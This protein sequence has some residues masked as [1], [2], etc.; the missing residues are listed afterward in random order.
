[1]V[2][3]AAPPTGSPVRRLLSVAG[4]GA[5]RLRGGNRSQP[6]RVFLCSHDGYGLGHLRRNVLIAAALRSTI[7]AVET[8]VVTGV[9]VDP[10]WPEW[11]GLGVLSM[12][13]LLKDSLGVYRAPGKSAAAALAL[14]ERLFDDAVAAAKPDLVLVDRHPYGTD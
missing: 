13:P 4:A 11:R 3:S 7:P 6:V 1:M 5:P 9:A 8:T 10:G 12:P 14:R 2:L